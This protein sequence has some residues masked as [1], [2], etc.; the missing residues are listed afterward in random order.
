MSPELPDSVLLQ[1]DFPD[2]H[3]HA[4]G[5]VCGITLPAGLKESDR[6]PEPIFTPA[7]KASTGHDINISFEDMCK[8]V[9][10]EDSRGLREIS[11]QLYQKA[12]DHARSKGIIIADTKFEFG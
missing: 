3:L 6:L 12:S 2:L 7:T 10:P 5:K 11:L 8:I 4:P 9:G 1:T